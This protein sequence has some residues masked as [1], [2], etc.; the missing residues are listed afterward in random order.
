[1]PK[2][3]TQEEY[4]TKAINI[5]GNKYDYSNLIYTKAHGMVTLICPKHGEF[6]IKAC[7]HTNQKQG[8]AKCSGNVQYTTKEFIDKASNVHDNFYTY[9]KTAYSTSHRKLIVTCPVHGDFEQL[10]YIHLQGHGCP[11]CAKIVIKEK[12]KRKSSVWSYTGWEEAGLNSSHFEGFKVYLIKCWNSKEEFYKIGKTFTSIHR[13]FIKGAIPYEWKLLDVIEGSPEY[14]STLEQNLH[15]TLAQYTYNP[16]IKFNGYNECFQ[17][18]DEIH[19]EF[20]RIS[21][22]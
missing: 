20:R 14:I 17:L 22:K 15:K 9:D 1:M 18:K 16:L 3:M 7:N 5:H 8:C 11:S 4:I 19:D 13:R 10:P 6:I 21:N 12:A 2:Q